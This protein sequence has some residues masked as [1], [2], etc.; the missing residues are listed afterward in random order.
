MKF[1]IV[2]DGPEKAPE[3]VVELKLFHATDGGVTLRA[4]IE[5]NERWWYLLKLSDKG[6]RLDI[7][8]TT[9]LGFELD[10]HRRLTLIKE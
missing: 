5:G 1:K 2:T 8:V 6:V 9:D 3:P 7:G 10:G 4:R